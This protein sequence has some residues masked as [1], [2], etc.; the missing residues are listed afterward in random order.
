MADAIV[1]GIDP[2]SSKVAY[3]ALVGDE[4]LIYTS[5]LGKS[6]GQS[7]H[8]SHVYTR[9]VIA[10]IQKR[11]PGLPVYGFIESAVVGRGGVRSTMVQCYTS[12]AIQGALYE[13]GIPTQI[14]NVSSW[15][16]QV[17]G[18]GN[19]TKEDVG[20]YLRLRWPAI[21]ARTGGNQDAIDASC[22]A[23]YG[24]RVLGNGMA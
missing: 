13:Q 4:C 3:A 9:R 1:L 14:A 20:E 24:Q 19:A 16:K 23:L 10:G 17:V 18:K 5:K 11:W 22:I 7:C 2:A 21:Y 8:N 12:G 15:K 6:G